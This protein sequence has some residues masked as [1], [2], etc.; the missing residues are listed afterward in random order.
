M[1][2]RRDPRNGQEVEQLL[3]IL[4]RRIARLRKEKHL[5]QSQLAIQSGCSLRYVTMVENGG[6]NPSFKLLHAL[7]KTLGM[8]IK[9]LVPS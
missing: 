3:G 8:S 9:E 6:A 1:V 5:T 4:G 2:G 7:A